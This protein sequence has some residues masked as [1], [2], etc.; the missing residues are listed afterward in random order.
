MVS[1]LENGIVV[2]FPLRGE[3][4][5]LNTPAKKIPSHGA[6][7]LGQRY[8][9][10]F[11]RT[12]DRKGLH[13]SDIGNLRYLLFGVPA[14]RCY[15]WGEIIYSPL[16]GEVVEMY[17]GIPERTRL[18]PLLDILTV[19]KNGITFKGTRDELPN[20]T[21]N[22]IIIKKSDFFAFFAHMLPGSLRVKTGDMVKTSQ[23]L[24]RVGHR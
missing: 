11:V 10:D 20:L 7:M 19:I 13:F 4:L 21:G 22:Y 1:E 16:D 8:A 14:K 9:Y 18:L 24:G 23:E 12:D 2:D 15:G 6:N 5:A 3:W 17:D